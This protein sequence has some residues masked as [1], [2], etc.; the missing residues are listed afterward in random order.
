MDFDKVVS[1]ARTENQRYLNEILQSDKPND[2]PLPHIFL[3]DLH[4]AI[5]VFALYIVQDE[6]MDEYLRNL[7][8]TLQM[9]ILLEGVQAAVFC[10]NVIESPTLSPE[11][12]RIR[13]KLRREKPNEFL[14]ILARDYGVQNR[15]TVITT[16][17]DGKR[18]FVKEQ[19]FYIRDNKAFVDGEAVETFDQGVPR[20]PHCDWQWT[21]SKKPP[22]SKSMFA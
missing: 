2:F 16:A 14:D 15:E 13:E 3:F 4:E 8:T 11:L 5:E 21:S 18:S 7:R 6:K 22:M 17:E 9:K 10:G 12:A 19:R 20:L 1:F